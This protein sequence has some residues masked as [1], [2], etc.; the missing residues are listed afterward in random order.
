MT[1]GR[2]LGQSGI[3]VSDIGFGCWAIGGPV[4]IDGE[5]DGWGAVDDGESAAAIRRALDLGVTFFDTADVY[6]A[7]HSEQVL[8]RALS[9]RRDDVVIATKFGYTFDTDRRAIT[10]EDASPDYIRRACRASLRRLGTDRIDLYQLH[11]DE[12]PEAQAQEVAGTLDELAAEGL[13][14]AYGWSTDDP[15]R[16]SA[17]ARASRCAA[18]QHELNVLADAPA[19]LAVCDGSGLASINRTPLA[20]GLLSGKY[21]AASKLPADDVRSSQQGVG[22]FTGGRA[23]PE[24]LARLDAVR[25]ALTSGGRTLAQGSLSWVLA[26][27]PRTVPIPGIRTVAQADQ[28]AAVLRQGPLTPEAMN[29]IAR[30]LPGQAGTAGDAR[31]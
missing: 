17:F 27:S 24:W 5:P 3:E 6:G 20:M 12:L 2:I 4:T 7:G 19:M 28:N 1:M 30:L 11:L 26:R 25:E 8:G 15:K 13:I 10:G 31:P 29:E 16:A 14:R 18:I 22:Y 23:A 21:G 9:G